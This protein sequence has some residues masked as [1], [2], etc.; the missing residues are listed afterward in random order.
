M[1]VGTHICALALVVALER[2]FRLIIVGQGTFAQQSG[3]AK[4]T[5][6]KSEK[7]DT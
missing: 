6:R 4:A 1:A 3:V 2:S 5:V 7:T